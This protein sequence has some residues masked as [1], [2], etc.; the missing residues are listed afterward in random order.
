[1]HQN[2]KVVAREWR[3]VKMRKADYLAYESLF[4][5]YPRCMPRSHVRDDRHHLS[6]TNTIIALEQQVS[7]SGLDTRYLKGRCLASG[8]N[9]R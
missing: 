1:M 3:V 9:R 7:K 6:Y 2:C 8:A 5:D 4:A